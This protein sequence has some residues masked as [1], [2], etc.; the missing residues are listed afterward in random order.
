MFSTRAGLFGPACF[1]RFQ[2]RHGTGMYFN[3]FHCF[4][5]D[6]CNVDDLV[7]VTQGRCPLTLG[8]L[9]LLVGDK[10]ALF[11]TKYLQLFLQKETYN[12]CG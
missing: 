6:Y 3:Q 8:I 4:R 9:E 7:G 5:A 10:I 1:V 2:I 11:F 12:I